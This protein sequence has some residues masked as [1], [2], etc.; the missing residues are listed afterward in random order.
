M[1]HHQDSSGLQEVCG[2]DAPYLIYFLVG[3]EGLSMLIKEDRRKGDI[4]G[5]KVSLTVILTHL[6]FVDDILIFG[7]GSVQELKALSDILDLY[8]K[9]TSM[10]LNVRKSWLMCNCISEEDLSGS[11][12]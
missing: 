6:L 5:I 11:E 10:E 8:C 1:V 7:E 2:R 3:R 9:E 4:K 12:K